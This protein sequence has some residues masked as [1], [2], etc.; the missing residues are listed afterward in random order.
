MSPALSSQRLDELAARRAT[1]AAVPTRSRTARMLRRGSAPGVTTGSGCTFSAPKRP[2]AQP[3]RVVA[4]AL[5]RRAV[6]GGRAA[7][8]IGDLGRR[9]RAPLAQRRGAGDASRA[10]SAGSVDRR[11]QHSLEQVDELEERERP[12]AS[13]RASTTARRDVA[14]LEADDQVDAA[15]VGVERRTARGGRSGRDRARPRSAAS[16]AARAPGRGRAARPT[17]S[18]TGQALRQHPQEPFRDR[19]ADAVAGA[20]DDQ[21]E[22]PLAARGTRRRVVRC[23]H[24]QPP[25]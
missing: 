25:M 24:R 15:E 18:R 14:L 20:D 11:R 2:T 8:R 1:A 5:D 21:L 6:H 3:L 23:R 13:A 17:T 10:R 22:R 9:L 19:A 12:L 16:P 7:Q 4:D